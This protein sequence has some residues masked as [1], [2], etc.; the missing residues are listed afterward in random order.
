MTV[1]PPRATDGHLALT[2]AELV[3][4][5]VRFGRQLGPGVVVAMS[6]D[7]GAGKTT[8]ARAICE[9]YGVQDDVT[10]PTFS[11]VHEYRSSRSPV[12]HVDLYRLSSPAEL[13]N[14]GWDELFSGTSLVLVEWPE[15]AAG[16]LP[17]DHIP[18]ELRHVPD[19]PDR[20]VLYAGG[21]VGQGP[22]AG[23]G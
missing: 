8:L 1:L 23:A 7:L 4:W 19:D 17:S 3:D 9:G 12:L 13:R 14:L 2:E 22:G 20:R 10:S 18:I 15:R 16:A 11:L 21:H 5:G 6:G